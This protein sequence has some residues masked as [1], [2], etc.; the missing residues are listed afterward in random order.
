[1]VGTSSTHNNKKDT[2]T[3]GMG[4]GSATKVIRK[5]KN[6]EEVLYALIVY[7]ND[8][9]AQAAFIVTYRV[10]IHPDAFIDALS[11]VFQRVIED[12]EIVK[13]N[14][15]KKFGSFLQLWGSFNPIEWKEDPLIME[16]VLQ[17][18]QRCLSSNDLTLL[19]QICFRGPKRNRLLEQHGNLMLSNRALVSCCFLRKDDKKIT[20]LRPKSA[21]FLPAW[22]MIKNRAIA[23]QMTLLE[24]DTFSAITS[25]ELLGLEERPELTSNL[26]T[27]ASRFY[28]VSNWV[29]TQILSVPSLK[30]QAE[31][32]KKF[33]KICEILLE[34]N[35][36]Q[37]LM[38]IMTG[39]CHVY[40]SRLGK[41]WEAIPHKSRAK[42]KKVEKLMS[43]SQNYHTYRELIKYAKERGKTVIPYLPLFLRDVA[44]L[45]EKTYTGRERYL[46]LFLLGKLMLWFKELTTLNYS[47]PLDVGVQK[48]LLDLNPL[49]DDQLRELSHACQ[50]SESDICIAVRKNTLT[51]QPSVDVEF[52]FAKANVT[53]Q[54]VF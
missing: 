19:R 27:V 37:S 4:E 40:V 38:Q 34:M 23:E 21:G 9:E 14:L 42:F 39:L 20:K 5:A 51:V 31:T 8:I 28:E 15:I 2:E 12:E 13:T 17:M 1:M 50:P 52:Y 45:K 7:S 36:F 41:V 10:S 54:I 33:I 29:A 26:E 6:V 11:R 25:F 46:N 22:W 49:S 43:Q 35:N 44:C 48:L 32:L 3:R 30:H 53:N 24:H 16:R 18:A 47:I